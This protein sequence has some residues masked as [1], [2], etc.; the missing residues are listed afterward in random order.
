MAMGAGR[1]APLLLP[2]PSQ[3][4]GQ[5]GA[6][7]K[8][9]NPDAIDLDLDDDDDAGAEPSVVCTD[10]RVKRGN[11]AGEAARQTRD[12]QPAR[13]PHLAPA[14]ETVARQANPDAIDLDDDDDEEAEEDAGEAG[15]GA[16]RG[17]DWSGSLTEMP[18]VSGGAGRCA[19]AFSL[20][21]F[22]SLTWTHL[23]PP[24]SWSGQAHSLK[25]ITLL[26]PFIRLPNPKLYNI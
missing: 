20:A 11:E 3:G 22:C 17:A 18:L 12:G 14:T 8:V 24:C 4:P 2:P 15:Q 9:S 1:R 5:G 6:A 13:D 21:S 7:P 10:M 16:K 26:Y 25:G 19:A 23:F